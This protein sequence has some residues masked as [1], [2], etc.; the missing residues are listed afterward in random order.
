VDQATNVEML[1]WKIGAGFSEN[2]IEAMFSDLLMKGMK[3]FFRQ[4]Y[5]VERPQND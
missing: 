3:D 2:E 4:L 1:F 5:P